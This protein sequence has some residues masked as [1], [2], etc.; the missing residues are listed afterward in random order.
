M[1]ATPNVLDPVSLRPHAQLELRLISLNTNFIGLIK[2]LTAT[3]GVVGQQIG[4]AVWHHISLATL[5][6][7]DQINYHISFVWLRETMATIY[8]ALSDPNH[9]NGHVGHSDAISDFSGFFNPLDFHSSPTI[10]NLDEDDPDFLLTLHILGP[11]IV[12]NLAA[13]DGFVESQP[14]WTP[15]NVSRT[16]SNRRQTPIMG[17]H[18]SFL[19]LGKRIGGRE[20][21]CNEDT[22]SDFQAG[23]I[24]CFPSSKEFD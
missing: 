14:H 15:V 10:Q 18:A 23:T 3:A 13:R 17:S 11:V 24:P 21:M 4:E 7:K 9:L 2:T 20:R 19:T 1:V 5:Q 8:Q 22:G 6:I 12:T 16:G